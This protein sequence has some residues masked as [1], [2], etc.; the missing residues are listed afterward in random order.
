MKVLLCLLTST[1]LF[2]QSTT[3]IVGPVYEQFS[4]PY[5][6]S[7]VVQ[8]QAKTNTG[9]ELQVLYRQYM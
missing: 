4:N 3:T 5:T 1:F 7:F 2:G 6:G 9:Y 8:S